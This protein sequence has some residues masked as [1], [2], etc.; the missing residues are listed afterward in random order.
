MDGH[1]GKFMESVGSIFSGG[2]VLPW[3]DR[4]IIAGFESE[5]AEATNEEQKSDSLMRLSWA[6]VH[7]RQPEDV[8]RGIGML[9]DGMIGMAIITGAFGL[10]GLVAGGIIAAASSSSSKKK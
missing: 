9:Q 8:N 2:D 1:V 6:L 7:S 5:I 3:C 4:D 10:V